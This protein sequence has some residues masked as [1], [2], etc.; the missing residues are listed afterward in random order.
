M[1]VMLVCGMT[2]A[3][4]QKKAEISLILIIKFTKVDM[5]IDH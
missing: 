4:A 2:F 3:S 1:A 5:Y